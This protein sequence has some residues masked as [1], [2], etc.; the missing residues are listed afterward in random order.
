MC[1]F[2]LPENISVFSLGIIL[3]IKAA[4]RSAAKAPAHST[5]ARLEAERRQRHIEI[6]FMF[7]PTA[8]EK[9]VLCMC[10]FRRGK[11]RAAVQKSKG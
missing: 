6:V 5:T 8:K 9:E 2:H 1:T 11:R 7:S 3:V 4:G 10:V